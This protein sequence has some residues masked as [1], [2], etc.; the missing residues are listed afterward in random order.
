MASVNNSIKNEEKNVPEL[1]FAEFSGEWQEKK[2]GKIY[3]W[4][5]TNSLS[6]DKLTDQSRTIQ[7]IHYGDIHSLYP[8]WFEQANLK[9][10]YIKDANFIAAVKADDF[11]RKGDVIIADASEDYKDIGKA[12][13][14][15]NVK[16]NSLVAGLHTY[17]AR[18]RLKVAIGF[19]CYLFQ[20]NDVRQK[21]QKIAQGISV[22]GISKTNLEKI[23]LLT[24]EFKEQQK[25]ANFLTSVD[26][27][28]AKLKRKQQCLQQ[29]KQG[30]MQQ[31]FSQ[32]LRFKED[33]GSDFPDWQEKKLAQV[34]ELIIREV[35]KPKTNYLAL[36]V[37]SHMKGTFQKIDFNPMSVAMDKLF[38]VR[39]KDLI[40]NIT[41]AWEGAIAI[42]KNEDDGALVSHRF[43]TYSFKINE[44]TDKYFKQIIQLKQFKYMLDLISPGGAGRN[45]VLS[46]K[47]FLK[48]KWNFPCP[49]EQQK[50]ADFLAAIDNKITAVN[51]QISQTQQFKQGLL[52]KMFV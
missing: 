33:D 19:S 9:I 20:S 37:R 14:I 1:R 16:E 30:I 34:L 12:I 10:P 26:D 8:S 27:K 35:P 52:Q 24:P 22:L 40:V 39:P 7:N 48:L 41:F 25:I 4:I 2:L 44:T 51:Q 42:V 18:P 6:R 36:G 29:Y 45:R 21:I 3:S 28:L 13:E 50:I 23:S 47:E 38:I 43:P 17:I 49:Q 31:I 5:R 11:C 15:I 46:K 32:Q